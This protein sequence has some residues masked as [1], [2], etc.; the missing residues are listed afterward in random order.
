METADGEMQG[1]LTQWVVNGASDSDYPSEVYFESQD[2]DSAQVASLMVLIDSTAIA[3]IPHEDYIPGWKSGV[4]NITYVVETAN[5][6]DY[7]FKSYWGLTA[8]DTLKEAATIQYFL[9]Q[10]L[11]IVNADEIWTSFNSRIPFSLYKGT[12]GSYISPTPVYV[13]KKQA[14]KLRRGRWF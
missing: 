6:S 3:S 9:D 14:R 8:Q 7:Y 4:G 11:S 12:S 10:A 1:C 5:D 2:L 13:S